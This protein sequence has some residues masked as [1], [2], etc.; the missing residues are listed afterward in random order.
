MG[1]YS[2][3]DDDIVQQCTAVLDRCVLAESME[4]DDWQ[5]KEYKVDY[6]FEQLGGL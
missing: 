4:V 2:Y 1:S 6:T 5:P 3:I